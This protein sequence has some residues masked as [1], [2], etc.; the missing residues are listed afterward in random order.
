MG[1]CR[2][3]RME[4]WIEEWM[5]LWMVGWIEEWMEEWIRRVG[6]PSRPWMAIPNRARR[7]IDSRNSRGNAVMHEDNSESKKDKPHWAT[8]PTCSSAIAGR[9]IFNS[10]VGR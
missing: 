9:G 3:E 6:L 4:E 10:A 5:A 2:E 1:E 7:D 8:A